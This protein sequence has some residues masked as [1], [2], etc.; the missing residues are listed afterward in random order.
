MSW[1]MAYRNLNRNRRR[2]LSTGLAIC[3]GFVAMNLLGAYIYRSHVLLSLHA[4]Y[5][6][7]KG[8]FVL[9]KQGGVDG[10]QV[11]PKKFIL[12][13][14]DLEEIDQKIVQPLKE[15]IEYTGQSLLVPALLSDGTKS[16]GVVAYSIDPEPYTKS[17]KQPMILK[18][19]S[20]WMLTWQKED[21]ELFL[22]SNEIIAITSTI[23]EVMG[24]KRPY[25]SNDSV[26]LATRNLDGDLNAINADLGAEHS[27]GARFLEETVILVPLKKL[28]EL[29]STE[30]ASSISLFLKNP[31]DLGQAEADIRSKMAEMSFGIDLYRYSDEEVNSMY[32]GTMGFLFVMA[33]FF[34]LLICTAVSLT[35]VNALTM[36]IIERTREIGTL[37]AIGFTPKQVR[38]IFSRESLLISFF[39]MLA[40]TL[41]SLI[42]SQLVNS[43][44]ILFQ[45]PGTPTLIQFVLNWNLTLAATVGIVLTAVTWISAQVVIRRKSKTKLVH[46]LHD[47]GES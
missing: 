14:Q 11:K 24:F 35:I 46:L 41:M 30:G 17:L 33:A 43:A 2:T 37:R 15:K 10:F 21:P 23:A 42:I 25:Q 8:H 26:Q 38:E 6:L 39:S 34:I 45:P 27:T 22:R 5:L 1:R 47:I 18:E 40:G 31:V 36:G 32:K 28:Q 4:I 3:V 19:A 12:N 29:L 7:Q 9:Y 13:K 20:D 16:R 44:H